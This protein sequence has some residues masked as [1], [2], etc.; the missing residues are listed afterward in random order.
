M[1]EN[2]TKNCLTADENSGV[3]AT[4]TLQNR[5]AWR[6]QQWSLLPDGQGMLS[7]S[8]LHVDSVVDEVLKCTGYHKLIHRPT[9]L[10]LE[11]SACVNGQ[12]NG[13]VLNTDT[14]SACQ[15]FRIQGLVSLDS[16]SSQLQSS[17]EVDSTTK[18]QSS[19]VGRTTTT[20]STTTRSTTSS[21]TSST[22][23]STTI[24]LKSN[25]AWRTA[26]SV[27]VVLCM[28]LF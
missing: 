25:D 4:P 9:G 16:T 17:S 1:C 26:V 2:S 5:R 28:L 20:R 21:I 8:T 3:G 22:T 15:K 12:S 10:A 13:L 11:S 27:V 19:T 6:E 14:N 24:D 7:T 18:A 23:N